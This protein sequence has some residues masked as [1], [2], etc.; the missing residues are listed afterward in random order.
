MS[1][2]Y[3]SRSSAEGICRIRGLSWGRPLASKIWATASGSRPLAP[4]PY[5]VSVGMP[6]RP[7]R[8]RMSAASP[9]CLSFKRRV[10][11]THT[12][13]LRNA[14]GGGDGGS[15]GPPSGYQPPSGR[16]RRGCAGY[17]WPFSY[18]TV[19]FVIR[20]CPP[21]CPPAQWWCRG[22]TLPSADSPSR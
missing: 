16:R 21:G 15:S 4:S 11:I 17:Q 10:C 8:R 9:I 14:D 18:K 20:R 13:F 19:S 2:Q 7:P 12:R 22:Q 5:T 3:R 6:S 1:I